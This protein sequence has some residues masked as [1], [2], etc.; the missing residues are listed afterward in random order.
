M[1]LL[2]SVVDTYIARYPVSAENTKQH[3]VTDQF[4]EYEPTS[5]PYEPIK[6]TSEHYVGTSCLCYV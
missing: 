3:S 1:L 6:E 2:S 5:V 4:F